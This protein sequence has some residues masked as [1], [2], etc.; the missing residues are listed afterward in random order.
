MNSVVDLSSCFV[1]GSVITPQQDLN[2]RNFR[3]QNNWNHKLGYE[4]G[5]GNQKGRQYPPSSLYFSNLF[6]NPTQLHLRKSGHQQS[7]RETIYEATPYYKFKASSFPSSY[8]N[9]N[10][11]ARPAKEEEISNEEKTTKMIKKIIA[12]YY[13]NRRDKSKNQWLYKLTKGTTKRLRE[14]FIGRCWDY[15]L[16]ANEL[17]EH[18]TELDCGRLWDKFEL[19]FSHKGPCNVTTEDYRPFFDMYTE[20]PITDKV[21]FNQM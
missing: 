9:C 13:T 14:I 2:N 19:A 5:A 11:S 15:Q 10:P 3:Y 17:E 18:S 16:K 4:F 6:Y 1:S 7:L 21:K 20:R 8:T 12:Q